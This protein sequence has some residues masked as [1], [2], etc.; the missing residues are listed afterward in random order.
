MKNARSL[1]MH[2]TLTQYLD[3]TSE[4]KTSVR[5]SG[6]KRTPRTGGTERRETKWITKIGD[7]WNV[8]SGCRT[9][10]TS[11]T[12]FPRRGSNPKA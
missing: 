7:L 12:L 5:G 8:D 11:P 4:T 6:D 3:V 2:L 1:H 10:A 9:P